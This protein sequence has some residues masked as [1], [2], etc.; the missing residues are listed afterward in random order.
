MQ[1]LVLIGALLGALGAAPAHAFGGNDLLGIGIQVGGQLLGAGI[2]SLA[3]SMRDPAAEAAKQ[4]EEQRKQ[5]EAFRKQ[6]EEIEA[7]PDLT[8]L[9]RE[10]LVL[11]L[12]TLQAQAAAFQQLVDVAEARQ[13]EERDK[14][15]TTAGLL[16]VIADAAMSSPSVVAA[17]ADAL[18]RSPL[19]QAQMRAQNAQAIALADSAVALG[20]G[21]VVP[22]LLAG[23]SDHQRQAVQTQLDAATAQA[24]AEMARAGATVRA[25]RP[26]TEAPLPGA[27]PTLTA[28]D[29]DLGK[30]LWIEFA[31]A[32]SDTRR[33]RDTLARR[34]HRLVDHAEDADIVYRLA[35]EYEI[36]ESSEYA[37]LRK[38]VGELL[39]QPETVIATPEKKTLGGLKVGFGRFMFGLARAQGATGGMAP[40]YQ[41]TFKQDLL[42]VI[43]RQPKGGKESRASATRYQNTD[44]LPGAELAR[45]ARDELYARLG[46]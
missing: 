11:T 16:S 9:Q 14:I 27:R 18:S 30:A 13:R 45:E 6:V 2:E 35:G 41:T 34:G 5:A 20:G 4:R 15:F 32:P 31:G 33:L 26:A 3:D 43:A 29:P 22:A 21:A 23:P 42:L 12:Q 38:D 7:Q 24:H 28:F 8:P 1:R 25:Q 19:Y 37:G 44:I 17:Q 36:R 39:E 46:I 10:R 40:Q